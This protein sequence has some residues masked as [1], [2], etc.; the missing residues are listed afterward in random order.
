MLLID[1]A[2]AA[3]DDP[4]LD[5][6]GAV[7]EGEAEFVKG[8]ELEGKAGF[9]LRAA[10]ADLLDRHRLEDHHL[11]VQLAEDLQI[12]SRVA[13]VVA[14]PSGAT[15]ASFSSSTPPA[16]GAGNSLGLRRLGARPRPRSLVAVV[17]RSCR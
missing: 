4:S 17:A 6:D 1:V 11:A 2:D 8:I 9:D 16:F 15:I 5:D 14:A 7:A 12:R 3:V 10:A 13:L